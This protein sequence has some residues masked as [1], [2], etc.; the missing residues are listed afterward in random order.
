MRK[1]SLKIRDKRGIRVKTY[2][3]RVELEP[4]ADGWRAFYPPMEDIGAS[5]W[6]GTQEEALKN[7][8]EVLSM[9][10]EE[11]VEEG[12]PIPAKESVT[13]SDGALVVVND[14]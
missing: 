6:G 4:D 9:I 2:V 13:V 8:Q 12:R 3:F 14:L 1:T 7:I 10:I 11:S 5:T